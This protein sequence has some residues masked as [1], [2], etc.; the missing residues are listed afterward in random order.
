MRKILGC[1]KR[2]QEQFNIIQN[3]DVIGVG[4]SGGKD[5][6]ALLYALSLYR[7]FAPVSY[8]LK[9]ITVDMGFTGF[10]IEPMQ[11]FCRS[12]NIELLHVK[13]QIGRVIFEERKEKNPCSLCSKMRRG[14]LNK[15]CESNGITKLALGH[16]GDDL[17]E[18]LLMSMLYES[19]ISAFKPVTQF[20]RTKII[21]IRPLIFA[22]E[23]DVSQAVSRHKLP[24]T[25]N[26]CPAS[27][28][29][30]RDMAK[31]LVSIMEKMSGQP[32]THMINALCKSN[33]SD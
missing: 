14:I 10:S 4:L 3:G 7:N 27:G 12:Q 19:R 11:E 20:E 25:K 30:K 26:P 17:I 21:Q 5:S 31:E 24:V 2:A 13:T 22:T 23:E 18:S 33:L 8:T 1:I 15:V 29:T 6:S 16:H 9:A 28:N 32:R